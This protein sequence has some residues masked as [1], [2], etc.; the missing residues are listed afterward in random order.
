MNRIIK[1]VGIGLG[2]A[3]GLVAVAA[4]TSWAISARKLAEKHP[5][6]PE[7]LVVPSD[8]ATLARGA[9]LVNVVAKCGGCHGADLG[10]KLFIDGGP[11]GVVYSANLTRG[12]G[13]VARDYTDADWVRAIRH[14]L[15]RDGTSLLVMPSEDYVLLEEQDLAAIIAYVKRVPPV[16]RELDRT[17][18]RVVGHALV[19]AGKLDIL[20]ASKAAK[21][22]AAA[23]SGGYGSAVPAGP[24]KEYGAYLARAG[25]CMGCHGPGLSGGRHPGQP[26]TEPAAANLTPTGLGTWKEADFLVAMRTGRRPDGSTITDFMPWKTVGKMSDEELRALWLFLESVPPKESGGH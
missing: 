24:T 20:S 11:L 21:V 8:S 16:D 26:E 14:G 19:A 2:V 5:L 25:G 17:R 15:R 13:G 10:G 1:R 23:S 22:A 12:R 18:L 3:T 9:H 7:S 4:G 6:P